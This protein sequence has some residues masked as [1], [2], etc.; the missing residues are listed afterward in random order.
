MFTRR[1]TAAAALLLAL[2]LTACTDDGDGGADDPQVLTVLAAASLTEVFEDLG[3][4]FEE[5]HPGTE[6]RFSFDSSATLA[7]QAAE[8]APAD[9]LATA[10]QTT[11]QTAVDAEVTTEEPTEFA[12]NV[13]VI[14][15]PPDAEG[16]ASLD[17]LDGTTWVMCV[18]TAPCG[19]V[20]TALLE[21][22]GIT[23]EPASFEPD[24]KAVLAKVTG[25]EADA[26]LV[27]ATD[28][29]AAEG[30]IA[31]HDI[32]G[33]DAAITSYFV[34]PLGQAKDSGLAADWVQLVSES[35]AELKDAGFIVP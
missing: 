14:A 11:M 3:D 2:P 1:I 13:L 34:A 9:V 27:Y 24:V 26:G 35:D 23:A 10:D 7:E 29:V 20:A 31:S 17:E 4:K 28:A 5:E 19:K 32:A 12:Q 6:V 25:G 22:A 16:P 30:E 8:G 21:D 33:S 15:T 18:D